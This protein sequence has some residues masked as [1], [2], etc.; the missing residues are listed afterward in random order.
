MIDDHLQS[1]GILN[2]VHLSMPCLCHDWIPTF[3]V[4]TD[5]KVFYTNVSEKERKQKK[6]TWEQQFSIS[7]QDQM[8]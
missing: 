6:I 7:E 4:T 5:K 3:F 1:P 2:L 8:L